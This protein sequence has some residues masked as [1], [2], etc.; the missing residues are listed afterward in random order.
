[1]PEVLAENP[2][3]GSGKITA[4]K[5]RNAH[6]VVHFVVRGLGAVLL[7]RYNQAMRKPPCH[8]LIFILVFTHCERVVPEKR[9]V[10]DPAASPT[11]ALS[12]PTP[13]VADPLPGSPGPPTPTGDAEILARLDHVTRTCDV[14]PW[15]ARVTCPDRGEDLLRSWHFTG[16]KRFPD[17][18][19]TFSS[20]I[21]TQ[22]EPGK[23]VAIDALRRIVNNLEPANFPGSEPAPYIT[24]E[25]WRRFLE[26]TRTVENLRLYLAMDSSFAVLA[27]LARQEASFFE[28]LQ[29]RSALRLRSVPYLM[30]FSRL[31][32]FDGVS[33]LADEALASG[34]LPLALACVS[35]ASR[36]ADPTTDEAARI[37]PWAA[38]LL[39]KAPQHLWAGIA[40]VFRF[41]PD[42]LNGLL[43]H[44]EKEWLPETAVAGEVAVVGDLMRA[45]CL[46]AVPPSAKPAPVLTSA[47]SPCVR[48]RKMVARIKDS[49]NT[50]PEVRG[51]AEALLSK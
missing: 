10:R 18:L 38:G 33:R 35:S 5:L 41:C 31:R 42:H 21:A 37:C 36:L 40:K 1:M 27:A 30:R 50:R 15:G 51:V 39:A 43:D 22:P 17:T 45:Q 2:D 26:A 20:Y 47:D 3:R 24:P 34:D 7:L 4:N 11:P 12:A 23:A 8:L 49:P 46:P 19:D 14:Q 29:G 28:E 48:L 6:S 32:G 44:L 9:D 16:K 13:P 25:A